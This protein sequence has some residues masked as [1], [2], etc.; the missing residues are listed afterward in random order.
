MAKMLVLQGLPAAGKS[1]FA[2]EFIKGKDNWVI[3]NR[4]SLR[5]M[6]GD[7]WVLSREKLIK[8]S[9]DILII[10]ALLHKYNVVVDDTNLNPKYISDLNVIAKKTGA[11]IEFKKFDIPLDELLKRDSNREN[12]VGEKVIRDFWKKYCENV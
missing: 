6:M 5:R 2:R 9:E 4:D 11:E 10:T 3:I 7:Y 8:D 1:T 12:P